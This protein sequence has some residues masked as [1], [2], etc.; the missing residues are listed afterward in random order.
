MYE[1]RNGG[2]ETNLELDKHTGE[3]IQYHDIK[4]DLRID[5][6]ESKKTAYTI[7]SEEALNQAVK[8]LKQYSPSYLHNYVMPTG[9]T[10]YDEERGVYLFSF[11]RVVNNILVSGD[12]IPVSVSADGF[13]TG[14]NVN[15]IDIENWPSIEKV[16]AKEKA[17]AIY[18]DQLNLDLQ[19]V[20]ERFG[21]KS[22]QYHLVYT[23][24]FN[25][26]PFNYLDAKNR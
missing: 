4:N 13:L 16:I 2:T 19:Y 22:D 3:I 15:Y 1:Y 18:F 14:L 12:Q 11:P 26:N 9:E 21:K 20:K 23:P 5:I 24:I 25:E 7:S 8:Y 17:T 10:F 6:G